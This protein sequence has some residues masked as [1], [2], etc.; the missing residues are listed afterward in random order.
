MKNAEPQS[1]AASGSDVKPAQKK[2]HPFWQVFWLSFL[3][4]SLAYAWYSFYVPSNDIAWADDFATAQATAA[5]SG[6][7]VILFYT[8]TW[9]VPCRIMKRTVWADEEVAAAVH[10][11]FIPVLIDIDEPE[12][13]EALERYRI[14]G[15]PTTI[16]TDSEGEVLYQYAGGISKT[17]FLK[18]LEEVKSPMAS[19]VV[20]QGSTSEG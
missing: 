7:R 1:A 12:A 16:V 8:A 13:A 5:A 17:D 18:V 11:G 2:S 15:T 9:C 10:D 14:E 3:V 20:P 19:R 6:D 4:V